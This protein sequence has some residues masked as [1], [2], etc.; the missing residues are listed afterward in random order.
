MRRPFG[1]TLATKP[2]LILKLRIT[3]NHNDKLHPKRNIKSAPLSVVLCLAL[4]HAVSLNTISVPIL[5][6]GGGG[7]ILVMEFTC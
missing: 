7:E 3:I 1:D 6:V 4:V 2:Y 5:Y